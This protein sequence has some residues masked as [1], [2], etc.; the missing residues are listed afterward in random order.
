MKT[1]LEH[2]DGGSNA[3]AYWRRSSTDYRFFFVSIFDSFFGFQ[4]DS[5]AV[6]D[7]FGNLVSIWSCSSYGSY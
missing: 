4:A 7:D 3:L 2:G 1:T 5:R 6:V